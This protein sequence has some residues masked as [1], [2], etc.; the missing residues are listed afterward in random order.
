MLSGGLVFVGLAYVAYL[1][2]FSLVLW[3]AKDATKWL[4]GAKKVSVPQ[5]TQWVR[6]TFMPL[7]LPAPA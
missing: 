3:Q 4:F 1:L 6:P 7:G 2:W 5:W